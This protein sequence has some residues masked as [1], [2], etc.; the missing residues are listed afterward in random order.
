M[1]KSV[2]SLILALCLLLFACCSLPVVQT[3]LRL[4]NLPKRNLRLL[5][6]SRPKHL[7]KD[8]LPPMAALC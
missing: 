5:R 3:R 7:R 2:I 6:I 4:L 1:K 8:R